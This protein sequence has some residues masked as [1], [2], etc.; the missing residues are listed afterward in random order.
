MTTE[1]NDTAAN[2]S[3]TNDTVA[4]DTVS[5][6]DKG[7]S[8]MMVAPPARSGGGGATVAVFLSL[9]ALTA[10]VGST[11]W[12]LLRHQPA[13]RTA[14][15]SVV[16]LAGEVKAT[17]S[18]SRDTTDV[19]GKLGAA[20]T[21]L[22]SDLAASIQPSSQVGALEKRI[23]LIEAGLGA[24]ARVAAADMASR[25]LA[26]AAAGST[27]PPNEIG[28]L[29]TL[30][31]SIPETAAAAGELG[32]ATAGAAIS[33][34]GLKTDLSRIAGQ[35]EE[36]SA[37]EARDAVRTVRTFLNRTVNDVGETL[38]LPLNQQS[39]AAML[40]DAYRSIDSDLA[41]AIRI[42]MTSDQHAQPAVA[43]WIVRAKSRLAFEQN[44]RRLTDLLAAERQV[45]K[46]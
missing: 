36:A 37:P 19:V 34:Q 45:D 24:L 14:A 20:V 3:A 7:R 17:T 28:R 12:I 5:P 18:A 23:T 31:S 9:L 11:G 41:T 15:E 29:V 40:R 38:G 2:D 32:K 16:A 1:A 44:V 25:S 42:A 35:I 21:Q 26:V 13:V 4:H 46:T 43:D 30:A 10:S 6:N 22:R 33:R 8:E 27:V 39:P